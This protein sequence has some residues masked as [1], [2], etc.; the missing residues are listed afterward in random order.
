MTA[1]GVIEE[2]KHLPR[3]EQSRVIQF[4]FELA[5]TRQLPGEKLSELAQ[6]MVECGDPAE[7]ERLKAEITRGF[8]GE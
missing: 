1:T 4:A 5:R 6:R 8:Y 7:V 3:V 2:I